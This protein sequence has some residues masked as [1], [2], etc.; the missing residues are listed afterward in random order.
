MFTIYSLLYTLQVVSKRGLKNMCSGLVNNSCLKLYIFSRKERNMCTSRL[1]VLL[2]TRLPENNQSTNYSRTITN[3]IECV[4]VISPCSLSF[5][6]R[7]RHEHLMLCV[8]I[9]RRRSP[10][11]RM[12][13]C[14]SSNGAVRSSEERK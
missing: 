6:Q 11:F 2:S 3:T 7:S 8:S 12:R 13:E 4:G 1:V 14:V 9:A 5:I 10:E